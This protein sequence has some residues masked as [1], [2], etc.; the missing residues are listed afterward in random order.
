MTTALTIELNTF[1]NSAIT[2]SIAWDLTNVSLQN[3][4][5]F[6]YNIYS[7]TMG[8]FLF[9]NDMNPNT[10]VI[11]DV[12]DGNLTLH[13]YQTASMSSAIDFQ[14][15][16]NHLG[17]L[18]SSLP[19]RAKS[20]DFAYGDPREVLSSST[21]LLDAI[22]T[23]CWT[24]VGNP[25]PNCFNSPPQDIL[26]HVLGSYG[27]AGTIT[28]SDGMRGRNT[29]VALPYCSAVPNRTAGLKD[30]VNKRHV[31]DS[32][33]PCPERRDLATRTVGSPP[34]ADDGLARF[35]RGTGKPRK[36]QR[37]GATT[38]S[39]RRNGRRILV[40]LNPPDPV[41]G[42]MDC[43][44]GVDPVCPLYYY[45]VCQLRLPPYMANSV[46]C[47]SHADCSV[48]F[49]APVCSSSGTCTPC[50]FCQV[51]ADDSVDGICPQD[52]CP[53]SGG[54]PRCVSGSGLVQQI[55]AE[56]CPARVPLSVWAFH[57]TDS[58][59]DLLPSPINKVRCVTPSNVLIGAVVVTQRRVAMQSCAKQDRGKRVTQSFSKK[60]MCRTLEIDGTPFGLDPAFL[61][62]SA[63]YNGKLHMDKYYFESEIIPSTTV[64]VSDVNVTTRQT[65]LGF[66]PHKYGLNESQ[67]RPGE[68]DL[69]RLFFEVR[70]AT[71]QAEAMVSYMAD[72]G[73][74]DEQTEDIKVEF[75][76]FSPSVNKFSLITLTF[77]WEVRCLC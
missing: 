33:V 35:V 75:V 44:S 2:D 17:I 60:T 28:M 13:L 46:D 39:G 51:D 68:G 8:D 64:S 69:F 72:G 1:L 74:I 26:L 19:P 66:F 63:I 4:P 57:E 15:I 49:Q 67:M 71:D 65:A 62:S 23:Y 7:D 34:N 9:E 48:A 40:C 38:G 22:S 12:P 52:M 18:D 43:S 59:L 56:R 73:F 32:A 20:I 36:A 55:T 5:I 45:Q 27:M 29:L 61:P 11:V 3:N 6:T 50:K 77:H 47:T 70:L 14:Q 42:E 30:P 54:W 37:H 31:L 25:D 10:K 24:G 41:T 76:T 21:V 53:G 58:F 16:Y